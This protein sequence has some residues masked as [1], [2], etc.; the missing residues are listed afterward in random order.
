MWLF[1]DAK[2]HS[3]AKEEVE[4]GGEV[5]RTK[6]TIPNRKPS[7]T[8][9][10]IAVVLLIKRR[11]ALD[12]IF[13]L[14]PLLGPLVQSSVEWEGG[15]SRTVAECGAPTHQRSSEEGNCSVEQGCSSPPSALRL[16]PSGCGERDLVWATRCMDGSYRARRSSRC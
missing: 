14:P 5:E 4:E 8:D 7:L 3:S 11:F 2:L 9:K 1:G 6:P 10:R 16:D 15:F 13:P 12:T